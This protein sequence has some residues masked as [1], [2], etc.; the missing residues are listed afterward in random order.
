[1][2]TMTT[3]AHT[4]KDQAGCALTSAYVGQILTMSLPER[5]HSGG[6]PIHPRATESRR[7]GLTAVNL[8][9]IGE[10]MHGVRRRRALRATVL[11]IVLMASATSQANAEPYTLTSKEGWCLDGQYAGYAIRNVCSGAGVQKTWNITLMGTSGWFKLRSSYTD[12]CAGLAD[13]NWQ[14]EKVTQS[15]CVLRTGD[16]RDTQRW[17]ALYARTVNGIPYYHLQNYSLY[18]LD[19]APFAWPMTLDPF[20]YQ[21]SCTGTDN[22]LWD[23]YN[24]RYAYHGI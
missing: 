20:T 5:T 7:R 12:D 6:S 24:L 23:L 14:G 13:G 11:M 9:N 21:R 8:L 1:V 16:Q 17:R 3:R 10:L 22:R 15:P 2:N 4:R 18:C 19:H